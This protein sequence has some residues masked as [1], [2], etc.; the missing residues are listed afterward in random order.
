[1]PFAFLALEV[2]AFSYFARA[3]PPFSKR[4]TASER[5]PWVPGLFAAFYFLPHLVATTFTIDRCLPI[6]FPYEMCHHVR[7][8]YGQPI[9]RSMSYEKYALGRLRLALG[10]ILGPRHLPLSVHSTKSEKQEL[11]TA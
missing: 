8:P 10:I 2:F 3:D 5:D 4:L 9:G 6:A 7:R 1:M 11:A